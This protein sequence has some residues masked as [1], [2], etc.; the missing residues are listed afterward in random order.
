MDLNERR[1][2]REYDLLAYFRPW[3]PFPAGERQKEGDGGGE[4][5]AVKIG[6]IGLYVKNIKTCILD[7]G[8]YNLFW[9]SGNKHIL[10]QPTTSTGLYSVKLLNMTSWLIQ[11]I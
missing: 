2:G 9:D 1:R 5:N 7:L 10:R 3:M 11:E 6:N 4:F 8:I